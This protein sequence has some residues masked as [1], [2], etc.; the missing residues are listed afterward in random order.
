VPICHGIA[1]PQQPDH[2]DRTKVTQVTFVD[3]A[4][5]APYSQRDL[6]ECSEREVAEATLFK[7]P[8]GKKN[9][10]IAVS[11]PRMKMR[12]RIEKS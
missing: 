11:G 3:F 10:A 9:T 4:R 6:R 5:G 2:L 1:L 8:I 7:L 12:E